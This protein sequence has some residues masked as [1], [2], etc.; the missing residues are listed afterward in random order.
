MG[1]KIM[2]IATVP[3]EEQGQELSTQLILLSISKSLWHGGYQ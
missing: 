2:L 3:D 1:R